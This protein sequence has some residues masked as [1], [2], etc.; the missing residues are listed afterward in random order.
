MLI[1]YKLKS[2]TQSKKSSNN[3][4][5]AKDPNNRI[6]FDGNFCVWVYDHRICK[7]QT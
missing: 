4:T 7:N 3:H 2:I 5:L 1:L 6:R